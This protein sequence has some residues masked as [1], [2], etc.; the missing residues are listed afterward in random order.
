[1]DGLC[2]N[3]DINRAAQMRPSL[4]NVSDLPT[5]GLHCS[6]HWL[7][8]LSPANNNSLCM[9]CVLNKSVYC[10]KSIGLSKV[11]QIPHTLHTAPHSQ[12]HPLTTICAAGFTKQVSPINEDVGGESNTLQPCLVVFLDCLGCWPLTGRF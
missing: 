6:A 11:C 8:L 4:S 2:E 7:L 12:Y 9:H 3:S 5:V 10:T 1:M